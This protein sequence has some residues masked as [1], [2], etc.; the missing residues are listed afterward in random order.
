MKRKFSV[1]V[2]HYAAKAIDVNF[3]SNEETIAINLVLLM[4]VGGVA[5]YGIEHKIWGLF[6]FFIVAGTLIGISLLIDLYLLIKK[7]I[8]PD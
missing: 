3:N 5:W 6:W 1:K 2:N 7:K 8:C 4:I